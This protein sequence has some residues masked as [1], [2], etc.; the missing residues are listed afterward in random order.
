ME[1]NLSPQAYGPDLHEVIWTGEM[2]GGWWEL[3]HTARL[4]ETGNT[5]ISARTGTQETALWGVGRSR[6]AGEDSCKT[7]LD[8][9]F[10][11]SMKSRLHHAGGVL[12][13]KA[14]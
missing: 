2:V 1:T 7:V 13:K 12:V 10:L 9:C 14:T 11:G 5:G 6:Q 4:A 3:T 8:I